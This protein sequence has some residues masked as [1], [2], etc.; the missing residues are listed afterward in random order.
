M[1]DIAHGY[2]LSADQVFLMAKTVPSYDC[3]QV[4]VEIVG[5]PPLSGLPKTMGGTGPVGGG[6]GAPPPPP[7]DL[8]ALAVRMTKDLLI[9]SQG[10]FSPQLKWSTVCPELLP[11]LNCLP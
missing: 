9:P 4:S 6:K 3:I 11:A 8:E 7:V 10:I 1:N 5:T 2:G